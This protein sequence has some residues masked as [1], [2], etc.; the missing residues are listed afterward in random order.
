MAIHCMTVVGALRASTRFFGVALLAATASCGATS[1]LDEDANLLPAH[2]RCL[3]G[4]GDWEEDYCRGV[5]DYCGREEQGCEL[6]K[7]FGCVCHASG[8]C[9]DTETDTCRPIS[10]QGN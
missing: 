7:A 2:R 4:G 8:E 3:D 5:G 6:T 1:E 10:P 9:W